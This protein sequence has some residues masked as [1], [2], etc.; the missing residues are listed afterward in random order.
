MP[1][2]N[3]LQDAEGQRLTKTF[4][5]TDVHPYPN[6]ATFNSFHYETESLEH[7]FKILQAHADV[8]DCLLKG[9]LH[10]QL[11]NERRAGQTSP[12]TPT[13]YLLLDLDFDEGFTSVDEF[14]ASIGLAGVSYILHHSSSSG[15]RA[16]PGLRVHIV[17][18]LA[19]PKPPALLKSWLQY[20]NLT[21]EALR[22]QCTLSANGY[23]LKWALDV[24]TCQN[25]KLIYIADP[26][27]Q[28]ID[29]LM[30]GKRFELHLRE[31]ETWSFSFKGTEFTALS[32]MTEARINEL[33]VEAGLSRR[34]AQYS[35]TSYDG[36]QIE[37]LK[38][39][40]AATVTGERE[41]RGFVYLNLNGGDS[42]GYY[43]PKGK[44]KYLRNFKGE[45]IVKL[46][47]IAPEY[48]Q[49]LPPS[50]EPTPTIMATDD[51]GV[52]RWVFQDYKTSVYYKAEFDGLQ[53]NLHKTDLAS[54][55]NHHSNLHNGEELDIIP[56]WN[57]EFDPTRTDII[58]PP[59]TWINLYQPSPYKLEKYPVA[60][61]CPPIIASVIRSLTVEDQMYDHF[62]DWLAHVWQTG[63]P[64]RT[65][66]LFRGTTGTGKG[67]L[68]NEI[69]APLFGEKHCRAI[70]MDVF[71]SKF[72]PWAENKLFVMIDE[73]EIDDRE[74]NRLINKCN[75]LITEKTIELH[76]KGKNTVPVRNFTN[77]I[78]AT[79]NRAPLKLPKE[80]RRW[81]V[82]Q[83]QE[84][85]LIGQGF[86]VTQIPLIQDELPQFAAFLTHR[87]YDET[88]IRIPLENDARED[89]F[90]STET[91]VETIFRA[92]RDGDLDFFCEHY[93]DEP[94]DS[95]DRHVTTY[96]MTVERWLKETELG[97]AVKI[98]NSEARAAYMFL[99][100]SNISP[101]KFGALAKRRWTIAKTVRD[102]DNV[103]KGWTV[104]F[105]LKE[106]RWLY[107]LLKKKPPMKVVV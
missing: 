47:D 56:E 3:F 60:A 81:N 19:E 82:A 71:D 20:L 17:V 105:K 64:T 107:K 73:G 87:E 6:A 21:V 37:Y 35:K 62:L 12:L 15:I 93:E 103:F 79:N 7:F 84:L 22:N 97:N 90:L 43:Y 46:E 16:K 11:Q 72:N 66:F 74:S 1:Q 88:K 80:D 70:D 78:V 13:H 85:S 28:D 5:A 75:I 42:W 10:K 61:E 30:A 106:Q 57:V 104:Q 95:I 65:G 27:C 39:P 77:L 91:S 2:I 26:V 99:T 68:F 34:K 24:T 50:N 29:D 92:L 36:E 69:L 86:D 32:T 33:R 48:Y 40:L 101:T 23:S 83:A 55:K 52:M 8:G 54:A 63:T 44:P 31:R 102:G 53:I 51:K 98:D 76:T 38:N 18:L 94:K 89:L 4:T 100:S 9:D 45:P 59:N 49:G 96:R 41:A 14:M 25:D 58:D 67:T